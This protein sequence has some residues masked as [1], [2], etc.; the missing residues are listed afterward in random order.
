MRS[1]H[2][3]PQSWIHAVAF[4]GVSIWG[5]LWIGVALWPYHRGLWG[6]GWGLLAGFIALVVAAKVAARWLKSS[7]ALYG[8]VFANIMQTFVLSALL[9]HCVPHFRVG[10]S[11]PDIPQ[12]LALEALTR[13]R[14]PLP[15][16]VTL[17]GQLRSQLTIRDLYQ[18]ASSK[19][20]PNPRPIRI[21]YTPL[22]SNRWTPTQPVVVLV[23]GAIPSD[24]NTW[25]GI[26]YPFVPKG[27][28]PGPLIDPMLHIGRMGA[29]IDWLQARADFP[30]EPDNL[31]LL[32]PDE[33]PAQLRFRLY[34][35]L[36]CFGLYLLGIAWLYVRPQKQ[37]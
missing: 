29:S 1:S 19:Q 33:S 13:E 22:V 12:S 26:L 5:F 15:G 25:T 23:D 36:F 20:N 9:I 32:M 28:E 7:D 8:I 10:L 21:A 24:Q 27:G 16:Y 2:R 34:V 6:Y 30:V 14:P 3:F 4:V 17:T 18:P 37:S 11:L 35:V 31:Y